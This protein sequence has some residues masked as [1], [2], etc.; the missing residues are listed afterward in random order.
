M[1]QNYCKAADSDA[2]ATTTIVFCNAPY[3]S[4]LRTTLAIVDAF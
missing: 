1:E 2:E 3:S 4:N